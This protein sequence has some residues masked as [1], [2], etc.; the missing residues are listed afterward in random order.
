LTPGLCAAG[1]PSWTDRR[2]VL[3]RPR[4][5]GLLAAGLLHAALLA[6]VLTV[7]HGGPVPEAFRVSSPGPVAVTLLP[8]P[9]QRSHHDPRAPLAAAAP[10]EGMERAATRAHPDEKALVQGD[11]TGTYLP[12]RVV[13]IGPKMVGVPD[14]GG[15]CAEPGLPRRAVLRVFVSTFGPPD[16]VEILEASADDAFAQ[17]LRHALERT[18]FLPGR[19]AGNDVPAYA[20]FEFR[21]GVPPGAT[22]PG[23]LASNRP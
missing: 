13:D 11:R 15:A 3:Q 4:G 6:L 23:S 5:P 21:I 1:G 17:A 2:T 7:L 19:L 14:C 22:A 16:R 18:S 12:G 8:E 20:D 10:A 9:D